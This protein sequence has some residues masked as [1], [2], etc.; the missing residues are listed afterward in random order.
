MELGPYPLVTFKDHT[1]LVYE[2]VY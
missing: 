2:D 1:N